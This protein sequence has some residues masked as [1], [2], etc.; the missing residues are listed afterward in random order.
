M[1]TATTK[2]ARPALVWLRTTVPARCRS[3]TMARIA[4][5]TATASRSTAPGMV[6]RTN[7]RAG[8]IRRRLR[9][10]VRLSA[11]PSDHES[12]DG[13]VSSASEVGD[14][15]LGEQAA[16]DVP[17]DAAVLEVLALAR[18]VE[19]DAGAELFVVGAHRHLVGV[20]VVDARDRELL[21]A[22]EAER[23]GVL[24]GHE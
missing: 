2:A 3:A 7:W 20:P 23:L 22:G 11:S 14:L 15:T 1:P 13:L 10:C 6:Q 17:E 8:F 5:L 21:A 12:S 18:R 19:A 24:A 4:S 9:A 16:Q